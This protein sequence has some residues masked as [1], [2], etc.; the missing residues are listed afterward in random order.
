[1]M[2]EGLRSRCTIQQRLLAAIHRPESALPD[3]RAQH[4]LAELAAGE[5][6]DLWHSTLP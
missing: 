2:F 3:P 6:L 4:E 1:M 5:I